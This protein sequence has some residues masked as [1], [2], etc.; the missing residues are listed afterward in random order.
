MRYYDCPVTRIILLSV[1]ALIFLAPLSATAQQPRRS[2]SQGRPQNP[3]PSFRFASGQSAL[4]IPFELS[5]NLILVKVR[6]NASPPLWFIFGGGSS[7]VINARFAKDLGLRVQGKERFTATGGDI[8]AELIH[9]VSLAVAGLEVFNQTVAALPLDFIESVLGRAI[10]GM[11]GDDFIKRFV[12]EIDYESGMM[13]IFAPASYKY[14]G[15]GEAL[16]IRF[17]KG[18]PSVSARI[19]LRGYNSVVGRFKVSIGTEGALIV[20]APF[21]RAH[22]LLKSVSKAQMGNTGDALG[23]MSR[24]FTGRVENVQ[25][26]RLI[27]SN[28]LVTFSQAAKGSEARADFDGTLG[29]EIFRRL[30]LILDYSRQRIIIEA[31]RHLAE[32][33]EADMSGFELI[34]EGRDFKTLIINEVMPNSPAA[35]AGL[36]EEDEL[37]AINGQPVSGIDLERIRQMLKQE[38]KEYLLSIKRGEQ[39]LQVKI[40][41]RRLI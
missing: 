11:I 20:N 28:P 1:W 27:I 41:L 17:I 34:A 24:S 38:G 30:K 4:K 37:I 16:P 21:V 9:G 13:N 40:K 35:E 2:T 14:S 3:V 25:L 23:E 26:G 33:V 22:Q 8:E 18:G 10:G 12:V 29:A 31:N 19:K 5:K 6:V 32:P 7:S 15:A 39:T 36:Q